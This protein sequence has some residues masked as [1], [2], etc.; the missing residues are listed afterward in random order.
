MVTRLKAPVKVKGDDRKESLGLVHVYTGDGKGKTTAALGLGLRAAGNGLSVYM[1]QF[2]KSGET[3]E[4]FSADKYLPSM[5]IVQF[6]VEVLSDKQSRIVEFSG[7]SEEEKG[8]ETTFTFLPDEAER[9]ACRRALEHA[10]HV[11][12]SGEY[13]LVILDEI[14][15]AMDKGLIP[16][17]DVLEL[18]KDHGNTELVLTGMDAPEEIIEAA[19]YATY[20]KKIRHPWMKGIKARRGIEY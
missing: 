9:E 19:D 14:N 1:I 3:G 17:E 2:L 10:K 16:L 8:K 11:I 20:M 6:G 7:R 18:I 12:S 4:L 13:D 15:C 5:R